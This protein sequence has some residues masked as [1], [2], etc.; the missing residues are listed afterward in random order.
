MKV[1]T[2][3]VTIIAIGLIGTALVLFLTRGQTEPLTTSTPSPTPEDLQVVFPKDPPPDS[4]VHDVVEQSGSAAVDGGN[5]LITA[6]EFG[7][8]Q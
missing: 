5:F 8:P 6:P 7:P 2:I 4:F 1:V 3:S